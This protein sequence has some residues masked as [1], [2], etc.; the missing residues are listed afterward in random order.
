MKTSAT[1][2]R[3]DDSTS[4]PRLGDH[5]GVKVVDTLKQFDPTTTI[6]VAGSATHCSIAEARHALLLGE[7]LAL[8]RFRLLIGSIRGAARFAAL[9]SRL[10]G[11]DVLTVLQKPAKE[12]RRQIGFV[13][14]SV[15]VADESH[16][17]RLLADLASAMLIIGN[18]DGDGDSTLK[19]VNASLS[20]GTPVIALSG[21]TG[22]L[23]QG[24]PRD[25][26]LVDDL[27][28]ML[29]LVAPLQREQSAEPSA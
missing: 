28:A 4:E 10:G 3:S 16:K 6:A 18:G 14:A 21:S 9:G 13:C 19:L 7:R 22:I 20:A 23:A 29:R 2:V 27:T 26:S 8:Q 12:A 17:H 5:C 1:R 24:L 11:G 15:F 25:V